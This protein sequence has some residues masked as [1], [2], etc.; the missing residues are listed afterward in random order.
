LKGY[1]LD[2][3]RFYPGIN[4]LTLGTILVYL[5]DKFENKKEPDPEIN[6]VRNILPELRGALTFA[7]ES[8]AQDEMADYWTL[9]SLAEL[10]VLSAEITQPVTRAYRKA[11]TA[12]RRNE[13]SLKSSLDQLEILRLLGCA[14]ISYRLASNAINEELRRIHKEKDSEDQGAKVSKSR[15]EKAPGNGMEKSS[16]SPDT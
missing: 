11:L 9:I 7:L 15:K 4:A 5:A 14:A 16:Y 13:S 1:R 12:S 3:D 8:K 10:R 2:L 6:W